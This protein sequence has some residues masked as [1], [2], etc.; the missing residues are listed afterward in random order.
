M[1][2]NYNKLILFPPSFVKSSKTF[3]HPNEHVLSHTVGM[4]LLVCEGIAFMANKLD[5]F[6]A[7]MAILIYVH[8]IYAYSTR[9]DSHDVYTRYLY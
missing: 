8:L 2:Y 5:C 6:F 7:N 9:V 3:L 4:N 1:R